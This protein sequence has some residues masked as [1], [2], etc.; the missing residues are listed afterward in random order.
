[1]IPLN[2]S[3][4]ACGALFNNCRAI[5]NGKGFWFE[6][7][8]HFEN[9]DSEPS[10]FHCSLFVQVSHS[11][12][13][14]SIICFV[15][16]IPGLFDSLDIRMVRFSLTHDQ[17]DGSIPSP[18]LVDMFSHSVLCQFAQIRVCSLLKGS[19]GREIRQSRDTA[20]RL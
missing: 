3:V 13:D 5:R 19:I 10:L 7:R 4:N 20:Q 11:S 12:P 16:I 1:L 15:I 9:S 6:I 2:C 18:A 17:G 8:V 14:V